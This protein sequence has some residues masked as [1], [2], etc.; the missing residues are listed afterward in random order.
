MHTDGLAMLDAEVG[1]PWPPWHSLCSTELW[2]GLG[3][4]LEN[5]GWETVKRQLPMGLQMGIK[6][7]LVVRKV[8]KVGLCCWIH[9]GMFTHQTVVTVC[10]LVGIDYTSIKGFCY[11]YCDSVLLF[12]F[13]E[14]DSQK[15]SQWWQI[16]PH[17]LGNVHLP[18]LTHI[19]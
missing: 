1:V 4:A 15:D 10:K 17:I 14:D 7:L 19:Q 2:D 13:L 3:R 11:C 9:N 5:Q 12:F 8:F 18:Q 16:L 6:G